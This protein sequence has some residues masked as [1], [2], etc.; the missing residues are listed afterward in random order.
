M[1][2]Q[3]FT[4]RHDLTITP[5]VELLLLGLAAATAWASQLLL[6]PQRWLELAVLAYVALMA[7]SL[8][9]LK[10]IRALFPMREGVFTIKDNRRE[11]YIWNLY[12]FILIMNLHLFCT[13][14]LMPIFLRP[15]F[16]R[17][18]GCKIGKGMVVIAGNVNAPHLVEIGDGVI[19]GDESYITAP[20]M[21][22]LK[23]EDAYYVKKVVLKKNCIIGALILCSCPEWWWKRASRSPR[24]SS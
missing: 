20:A 2:R 3:R 9:A 8:V 22:A 17:L 4:T 16:L 14:D 19:I 15:I 23:Q 1:N 18:L 5:L 10:L 13:S 7:W 11:I 21:I 12:G 6:G 24:T